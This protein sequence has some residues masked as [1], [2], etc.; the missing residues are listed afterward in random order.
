MNL[1]ASAVRSARAGL[2]L[3][4]DPLLGRLL[5]GHLGW[6]G[7]PSASESPQ[8][9]VRLLIAPVNSAGQ[10]YRW[11]RAAERLP[12]VGAQ[13]VTIGTAASRTFQFPSDLTVPEGAFVFARGWQRRQRIAVETGFTHVLLE[14]GRFL[15]GTDP[16]RSPRD[17][18]EDAVAGGLSVGLVW[19]GSDIRL[20][21]AHARWE[22]DSPFGPRGAYPA[23]STR[24][25]EAAARA[26]RRLVEDSSLPVFVS[27]PGLLDVPRSQWLPV[28]IEPEL[29]RSDRPPFGGAIPIVA[30]VPSNSPMKGDP[31]IDE[32]LTE[33]ADEGLIEYRRLQG[34]PS[35]RMPDV[36]RG[37]DIVLDQFR[38]GD[39]G[40]AACEAMAAGRLVIGHVHPDVRATVRE[41]TG[42]DLPIIETRV[43]E[44]E[45]R[46]REILRD[47]SA[48]SAVAAAGP[49]YVDRVHDG[50][51]SATAL[52]TF[53][54]R[55]LEAAA[56]PR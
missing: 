32:M 49:V 8:G 9:D 53:L 54:G 37:A 11:A 24:A 20:P 10:G 22:P 46:L 27:T 28:V 51:M 31:R 48:W 36:Y 45:T 42:L 17:V 43:N 19:H 52:G 13:N 56:L 39:Y 40:V 21:K 2:G 4:P 47:P 3:I 30:Y 29:W 6:R 14:S 16:V 7:A 50:R 12:G 26:N 25:L 33:L 5:P 44:V 34:I 35:T 23:D 1:R 18:A 41:Q 15:Y 55:Q 38:L